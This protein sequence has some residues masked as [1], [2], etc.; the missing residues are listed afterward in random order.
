[1]TFRF[2]RS[3]LLAAALAQL[4]G[5]LLAFVAAH[6]GL[7]AGLWPLL[8]LQALAAAGIAA[9]LRSPWWWIVFQLIF[10]PALVLLHGLGLAPG[11]YLA[12]FVLLALVFGNPTRTRVPLFL[13]HRATVDALAALLPADRPFHFLDVGSGTGRVVVALAR[14][15][16]RGEFTGIEQAV[17]P[18]LIARW[19]GRGLPNL[20]LRR[21]D[22]FALPW[23]GY[24]V[25]YAFLSPVPMPDLWRKARAELPPG[26][27]VCSNE[28][29]I[30]GIVPEAHIVPPGTHRPLWLYRVG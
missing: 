17:L 23:A 22:A 5:W 18:H 16:P 21:G 29:P 13:S 26:S 28:F 10:S 7:V 15:F 19:R 30:P 12:A 8:A 9:S 2:S 20:H 6:L 1:M 27:L 14:A 3:P 11:W 4:L 24:D 25:L